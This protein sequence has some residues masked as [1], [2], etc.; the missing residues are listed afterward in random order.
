MDQQLK[1]RIAERLKELNL[2]AR[3][4]SLR[5]SDNPDLIRGVLRPDLRANPRADT[6]ALLARALEVAPEW[7]HAE[8]EIPAAPPRAAR[9]SGGAR[10]RDIPLRGVALGLIVNHQRG[11]RLGTPIAFV[12]RPAALMD[13]AG[14]YAIYVANDSMSPQHSPGELRLVQEA[15]PP[16]PGDSVIVLTQNHENDPGQHYIKLFK[17]FDGDDALLEQIN[18]RALVRI[19]RRFIVSI[20]RVLTMNEIFGV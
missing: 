19:P 3:A 9:S 12:D 4:A 10:R 1:K 2:S 16:A 14:V 7:F 8:A 6:I 13:A 17:G 5:V 20:D 15:R 11:F 18:P